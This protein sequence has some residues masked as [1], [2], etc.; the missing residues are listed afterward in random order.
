MLVFSRLPMN[1]F[2][3]FQSKLSSLVDLLTYYSFNYHLT[4]DNSQI[5]SLNLDLILNLHIWILNNLLKKKKI[6]IWIFNWHL[7]RFHEE[8]KTSIFL[9][10]LVLHCWIIQWVKPSVHLP[11][12]L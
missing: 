2:F 12:E 9:T 10:K 11:K 6:S 3:S 1:G 8:N 4:T 7:I 5:Y